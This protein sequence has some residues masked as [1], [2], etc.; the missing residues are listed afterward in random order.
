[1]K[2]S[3]LIMAAVALCCLS[4][5]C[6]SPKQDDTQTVIDTNNLESLTKAIEANPKDPELY[7]YRAKFHYE[8][9]NIK[10]AESD[11]LQ[12]VKLNEKKP[13]YY[14]TASDIYFAQRE[15]DLAEENLQKALSIDN[16]FN[17]ARLKLAELYYIQKQYERCMTTIDEAT[18][19]N[20][21]NPTAY[22]IKSFCY[23]ETGDTANYL[24]LLYLVKDQN[25]NEVKA[26]LEL[27]YFYQQKKDPVAIDHYKNALAVDP[28]N[29]E[30]NYN[31]GLCYLNFDDVEHA[32][33]QFHNLLTVANK[34]L[35]VING[36]YNLGYIAMTYDQDYKGA[37]DFFSKAVELEPNFVDAFAARGEA[38]ENLGK[39]DLAR[40]DYEHCLKLSDNFEIAIQGLNALDRKK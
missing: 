11:I 28:N 37:I 2:K 12:A 35:Y 14:V 15:T 6:H 33:E 10:E 13:Q 26:H 30:V 23:K 24:R 21:H 18:Q 7:Y 5:S 16:K 3:L 9:Q 22:L 17:E 32:K 31:L 25:P 20:R 36:L 39:Y 29:Q 1:M 40:A 38:Y 4:F 27:G 19:Q 34:G 8:H